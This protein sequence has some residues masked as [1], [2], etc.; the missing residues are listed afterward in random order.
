MEAGERRRRRSGQP[1]FEDA[2]KHLQG[3]TF[4]QI[5]INQILCC[6][7]AS[8]VIPSGALKNMLAHPILEIL[9]ELTWRVSWA[10]SPGESHMQPRWPSTGPRDFQQHF[11][12]PRSGELSCITWKTGT[13][14]SQNPQLLPESSWAE[15]GWRLDSPTEALF[16]AQQPL[17]PRRYLSVWRSYRDRKFFFFS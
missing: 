1:A 7:V 14:E 13:L 8:G 15:T 12:H 16:R 9:I 17:L 5:L 4:G 10:C 6:E 2:G 11:Y 3:G